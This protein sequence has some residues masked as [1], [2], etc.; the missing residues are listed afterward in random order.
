MTYIE[1]KIEEFE[2]NCGESKNWIGGSGRRGLH[3][4]IFKDF[5]THALEVQAKM[6]LEGLPE[7]I[8]VERCYPSKI[9]LD[10]AS[11]FNACRAQ[12]LKNWEEQGLI[13]K[14]L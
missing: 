12:T 10:Q 13:N 9:A 2:K 7:G 5:L 6:F 1:E 11:G 14:D 4:T 3:P 8:T